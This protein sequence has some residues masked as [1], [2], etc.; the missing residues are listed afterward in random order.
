MKKKVQPCLICLGFFI[1]DLVHLLKTKE[2]LKKKLL[3]S[4]RNPVIDK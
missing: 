1:P 3:S 4:Y 2:K